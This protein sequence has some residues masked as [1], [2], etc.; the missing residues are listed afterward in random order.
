[1]PTLETINVGLA[2]N[3][4]KGDPLRNAMQKVNL[5]FSALNTAIQGVLDGKGQ[6]NGYASL[7]ADGRLLAAQAPVEYSTALPTAAHDLNTYVTPGT[8]YQ[9]TVAGAT[10]PNGVNY[11]VAQVGFLEVVATG[12]PVVQVYTTRVAGL[13]SQRFWRVRISSASW[14]IWKEVTDTTG[15][16]TYQGGMAA[17]QDLNTYTQRGMWVIGSSATAAGGTN[18]PIGQSGSLIVFSAGYPG[19]PVATSC[20]QLY[21]AANSG[22]TFTRSLVSATWTPWV[23]SVDSGQLGAA[24][25][26][27]T[28][29]AAGQVVQG[30]SSTAL[31]AGDN[32]NTITNPGLYGNNAD[33]YATVANNYP[34]ALAGTLTVNVGPASNLQVTQ[35]Y[36]TRETTGP[37]S[38]VRVRFGSGLVWSAWREL[39]DAA[40]LAAVKAT[41]DAAIPIAQKDANG[42]VA[43]L[44][45][46]RRIPEGNGRFPA[47]QS[48]PDGTDFNAFLVSDDYYIRATAPNAPSGWSGQGML[49]VRTYASMTLQEIVRWSAAADRWWRMKVDAAGNWSPWLKV[50]DTGMAMTRTALT[51]ATDANTLTA[52]NTFYTWNTQ[53]VMTGANFPNIP[54]AGYM[55][56]YVLSANIIAQELVVVVTGRK[57]YCFYRTGNL[58]TS[59]W[60]VWKVTSSFS[61]SSSMPNFD[62]G[63]I[64]VDGQGWYSWNGTVYATSVHQRWNAR[65]IGEIVYIN[66]GLAGAEVPPT[67]NLAYRYI[68]LSAANSYNAGVLTS[69]TVSGS[70][71]LINAT[72]VISLSG[73][74]M[75]GRTVRLI[76][77]EERILRPRAIA[78]V[79]Q[80][81]AFQQ[82]TGYAEVRKMLNGERPLPTAGGALQVAQDIGSSWDRINA[83]ASAAL[84]TD[85]LIIDPSSVARTANETRMRNLGV[86]AFMRIL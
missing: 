25:G 44:D 32:L 21:F 47:L 69:E 60:Q 82:F 4:K 74:P 38:F 46:T 55:R 15:V 16:L 17:A 33:A 7:G 42:G 10:S 57:P 76:N 58:G 31:F 73:S 13:A 20:T 51:V 52:D 5:N 30:P 19:G 49:R 6:A 66:D 68:K 22:Q 24:N 79:V 80:D 75:N 40:A 81:D 11:P 8:F 9:T 2:P 45:S 53:T 83:G 61:T 18:F 35:Q 86:T 65:A 50:A 78:N 56:A 72:A 43:P 36:T 71:P 62:A 29:N 63:D 64:Y 12:T 77:T 54:G 84:S 67:D 26:V 48:L 28:L 39:A 41:A 14:S 85:R 1:M 37:R 34:V 23:R 3:D 70:A 27:A 59:T